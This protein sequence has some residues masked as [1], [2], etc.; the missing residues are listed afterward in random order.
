[1]VIMLDII[2]KDEVDTRKYIKGRKAVDRKCARC[3]GSNTQTDK[4]GREQWGNYYDKNGKQIK[5]QYI[6]SKCRGIESYDNT[7]K[8]VRDIRINNL[9]IDSNLAKAVI[10]QAVI[11]KALGIE[12]LNIKYDNYGWYIDLEHINY[13]KIDAKSSSLQDYGRWYWYPIRK[14]PLP[15][16]KKKHI[17]CNTFICIGYD[18]ERKNIDVVLIIPSENCDVSTINYNKDSKR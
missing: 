17:L 5:G 18:Y 3:G 7:I 11:A 14:N 15:G 13:G 9:D 8:T 4:Y 10:S 6:C 12:D 2:D 16:R 1:M